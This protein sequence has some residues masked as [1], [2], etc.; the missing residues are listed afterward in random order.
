MI[1]P[2]AKACSSSRVSTGMDLRSSAKPTMAMNSEAAKTATG[3]LSAAVPAQAVTVPATSSV[4]AITA[5][6]A[7][8]GV[9]MRCEDRA[10]GVASACRN[11]TGRIAQVMPAESTAAAS[12]AKS[13]RSGSERVMLRVAVTRS[14]KVIWELRFDRRRALR[15]LLGAENPHQ[16]A[17]GAD[18]E[19]YRAKQQRNV[20]AFIGHQSGIAE[21][22]P[23]TGLAHTPAGNR[24][25]QHGDQHDRGN[26]AE[27]SG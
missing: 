11:S 8:C 17:E 19:V 9:G 23:Q 7:P 6:P 1:A 24:D 10:F 4:A 21:G 16:S 26:Q 22:E 13:N 14:W 15:G 20:H 27:R 3:I 2:T 25:R 12:T 5:M 18:N